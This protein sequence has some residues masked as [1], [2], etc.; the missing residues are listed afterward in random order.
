MYNSAKSITKAANSAPVDAWDKNKESWT[1][2]LQRQPS[3]TARDFQLSWAKL[4]DY[5]KKHLTRTQED[6]DQR[7]TRESDW[8][9]HRDNV[10]THSYDL[11]K[12]LSAVAQDK[13]LP[14]TV[15]ARALSTL[16]EIIVPRHI[17]L[18][19]MEFGS[20]VP[21][22][23]VSAE[24][25]R[26]SG[27]LSGIGD[28]VNDILTAAASFHNSYAD[29]IGGGYPQLTSTYVPYTPKQTQNNSVPASVD[30]PETCSLCLKSN[31]LHQQFDNILQRVR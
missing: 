25:K 7:T 9:T 22:K 29:S 31:C 20:D 1:D 16:Q 26:D 15:S 17:D 30:Q 5:A 23:D 19:Q 18:K 6:L 13:S 3:S 11:I 27:R 12:S 24:K 2:Y 14:P 28:S 21:S 10:M 8:K 4:H